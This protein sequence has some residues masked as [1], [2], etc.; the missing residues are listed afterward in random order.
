MGQGSTTQVDWSEEQY[1][2]IPM[3]RLNARVSRGPAPR[4]APA[5]AAESKAPATA[6]GGKPPA[7]ASGG[8]PPATAPGGQAGG[9]RIPGESPGAEACRDSFLPTF[10]R[11]L[12][13]T[14]DVLIAPRRVGEIVR[15][16]RPLLQLAPTV[17][18][19]DAVRNLGA[20]GPGAAASAANGAG[21]GWLTGAWE[22]L[23][24]TLGTVG[25]SLMI[26]AGVGHLREGRRTEGVR[27]LSAGSLFLGASLTGLWKRW[28]DALA[29][30]LRSAGAVKTLG[31][32]GAKVGPGAPLAGVGLVILGGFEAYQ[33]AKGGE[34]EKLIM[35]AT[36]GA[37][38]GLLV[39]SAFAGG[40][41]AGVATGPLL[42]TAAAFLLLAK[43]ARSHRQKLIGGFRWI[44]AKLA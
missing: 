42:L 14:Q 21:A 7:I 18:T 15:N 10:R 4:K 25:S 3:D 43:A 8:K 23:F 9:G 22:R 39:A 13:T 19:A 24:P 5:T 20:P 33:A 40:T 41:V 38:G 28:N 16:V 37:I 6:P 36:T 11:C 32:P 31:M 27:D 26:T 30:A 44:R 17:S 12:G 2:H 35:A 29:S 34:R 1:G